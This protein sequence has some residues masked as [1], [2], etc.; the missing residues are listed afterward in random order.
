MR[1]LPKLQCEQQR[2]L[3]RCAVDLHQRCLC[4]DMCVDTC[5]DMCVDMYVD[6]YVHVHVGMDAGCV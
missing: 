4:V 2:L 1:C 5:V 6:M 3:L